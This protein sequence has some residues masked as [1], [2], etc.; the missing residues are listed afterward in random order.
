[1]TA[2]EARKRPDG[3][4]SIVF[5]GGRYCIRK[6]V[7]GK[8][9]RGGSFATYEEALAVLNAI[10]HKL[11]STPHADMRRGRTVIDLGSA[12]LNERERKKP[13]TSHAPNWSRYRRYIAT[14]EFAGLSVS[15]V[16][17]DHIQDWLDGLPTQKTADG[18]AFLDQGTIK[19][20][21]SLLSSMYD[22]ARRK[23]WVKTNPV[24]GALLPEADDDVSDVPWT[25]LT[26]SE[27]E[28]LS[29][30]PQAEDGRDRLHGVI[31][32][33]AIYTGLRRGELWG[34]QWLDVHLDGP[35][36][37]IL[38]RRSNKRAP[39]SGKIRHV[40][41]LPMA[42]DIL[43]AWKQR[44]LPESETAWVFPAVRGGQRRADNAAC[45]PDKHQG[46]GKPKTPGYCTRYVG[47]EVRFHDLR[48]TC[49]SH[50][51]MGTWGRPWSLRE[52]AEFLGH[53]S[54]T[55]TE[56]YS[57]LCGELLAGYAAA[58]VVPGT[59][60][61]D[62]GPHRGGAALPAADYGTTS[63]EA[64]ISEADPAVGVL[65]ALEQVL[66][67]ARAKW[68]GCGPAGEQSD[69][70]VVAKLLKTLEEIRR[71]MCES[72]ARPLAPE[73]QCTFS[74]IAHL[75]LLAGPQP[76]HLASLD[77]AALN[78]QQRIAAGQGVPADLLQHLATAA[79][80]ITANEPTPCVVVAALVAAADPAGP[81]STRRALDLSIFVREAVAAAT[82]A[83]ARMAASAG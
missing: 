42:I 39:K 81:L 51:A 62:D 47:R 50:L 70:A 63:V 73:T 10:N 46:A 14:A 65:H 6:R 16:T 20:I 38:V 1:M 75:G 4:G 21:K 45:W 58:T 33:T 19:K 15:E 72:N 32:M 28:S 12:Y 8:R 69:P 3:A 67:L 71:A 40:P 82:L 52:I 78:V 43:T 35:R 5:E 54:T 57:H 76:G 22:Y 9:R 55:T 44:A 13:G 61:V 2:G 56:R 34:L 59:P 53:A 77:A 41:L 60:P 37:H 48:H 27:I 66:Q 26:V 29:R 68:P 23:R 80:C 17:T 49:A 25:F 36:P 7:N 64:T 74:N 79:L 18:V 24:A 30:L 11:A 31:Y 83:A